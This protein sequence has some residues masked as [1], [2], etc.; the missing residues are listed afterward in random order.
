MLIFAQKEKEDGV[1]NTQSPE[2]HIVLHT[3]TAEDKL[4]EI[5]C[6][7]HTLSAFMSPPK[8]ND[9]LVEA[10]ETCNLHSKPQRLAQQ[11]E[12]SRIARE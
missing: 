9:D 12:D 10:A 8:E 1:G 11:R 7:K 2:K 4:D 5:Y 3:Y 6:S